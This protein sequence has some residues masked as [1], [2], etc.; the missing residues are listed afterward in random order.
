MDRS[1]NDSPAFPPQ[2]FLDF[3]TITNL[4][5]GGDIGTAIATVDQYQGA[6]LVQTTA[7]QTVTLPTPTGDAPKL[8]FLVNAGSTSFTINQKII[9]PGTMVI[10]T[11]S[12][13]AIPN[14]GK[15]WVFGGISAT[16]TTTTS[17]TS[18]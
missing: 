3:K 5:S 8:F 4:A 6:Y 12:G 11:Y 18:A 17:T 16:L 2:N 13:V 9:F 1:F 15:T 14:I 10:A 7:S